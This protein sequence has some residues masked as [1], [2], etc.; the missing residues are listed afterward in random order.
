MHLNMNLKLKQINNNYA[1]KH[2]LEILQIL[3]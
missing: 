1:N 2:D 3:L